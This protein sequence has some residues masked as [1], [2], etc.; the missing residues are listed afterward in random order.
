M[1]IKTILISLLIQ[2]LGV[3]IHAQS[4]SD[5]KVLIVAHNPDSLFTDYYGS[6]PS[7]RY[8][9][10]AKTR[11]K[12]FKS[13]LDD[14]FKTVDVV[15]AK[16]YLPEQSGNYDVTIFDARPPGLESIDLGLYRNGESVIRGGKPMMYSRYLPEDFNRAAIMIGIL[17]D[18]MTYCIPSKLVTQCH[19]LN[20]HALNIKTEH[21]IFNQPI[22]VEL[23]YEKRYAPRG[24]KKAYS[25][26]DF[27]SQIDMWRVQTESPEDRKGYIIGQ[28]MEGMDFEDSPECEYISGGESLKDI[29][30]MALGRCANL[31]HWGFSASPDFMTE[32][33][34]KVFV[35]TVF[36]MAQ[37]NGRSPVVKM[38]KGNSRKWNDEFCYRETH[39]I[40]DVNKPYVPTGN[41]EAD[42]KYLFYQSNYQYFYEVP[43][44]WRHE[45]DEEAKSLGIANNDIKLLDKCISLL[46]DGKDEE[47]AL[48]LLK[49][50]T[51][52]NFTTAK[53]WR[54]WYKTFNEYLFFTETGGFKFMV[55]TWNNPKL[56]A[57]LEK[58]RSEKEVAK[59]VNKEVKSEGEKLSFTGQ[60]VPLKG[61]KY[62][63]KLLVDIKEGWHGY[64]K[65]TEETNYFIPTTIELQLPNGVVQKKEMQLPKTYPYADAKGVELFKGKCEFIQELVMDGNL[66][67]GSL[68]KATLNYQLC[69][70]YMCKPPADLTIEIKL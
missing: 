61:N 13:L 53:E 12:E 46:E 54:K 2:C 3:N 57:K 70:D 21:E 18:D 51:N 7:P 42:D 60:L 23:S 22:K 17:T 19:C 55:D 58:F 50:Y 29:T 11:G 44:K 4:K 67:T 15:V 35:N 63:L 39:Q 30:G 47:K 10:L 59:E 5:I 9:E 14:Y 26:H 16:D 37:F 25:G 48:V 38:K 62:Q 33:A 66:A 68:I 1:T 64:A 40:L 31:F 34:K 27:P 24:L 6:R 8:S 28:I 69:D 32:S 20:A 41:K 45:V 43:G 65:L 36:Y 56:E 49:R 52:Y